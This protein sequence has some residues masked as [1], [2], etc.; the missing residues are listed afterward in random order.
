MD[1]QV[2]GLVIGRDEAKALLVAEPLDGS[3]S[4]LRFLLRSLV[5]RAPRLLSKS[6]DRWHCDVGRITRPDFATVAASRQALA[7][8]LP[9]SSPRDGHQYRSKAEPAGQPLIGI[10]HARGDRFEPHGSPARWRPRRA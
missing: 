7:Q 10:S 4:H 3:G 2:L 1:E 6:Y 5:L 8:R 9:R